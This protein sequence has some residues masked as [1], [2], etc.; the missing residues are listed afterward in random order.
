MLPEFMNATMTLVNSLI[1]EARS[2][3][4][5][6]SI[7]SGQVRT[8]A[9]HAHS[10]MMMTSKPTIEEIEEMIHSGKLWMCG[11]PLHVNK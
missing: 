8:I 5:H 4:D 2:N 9:A 10:L 6:L 11:I 3:P 1:K 7:N